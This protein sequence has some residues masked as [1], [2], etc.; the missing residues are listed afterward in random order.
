MVS[1]LLRFCSTDSIDWHR[2]QW[3]QL[4]SMI[5]RQQ[6]PHALLLTGLQGLGKQ[7]FA[8]GLA[9][10]LLC[11]HVD[12]MN[13]ACG[14]CR[15]CLWLASNSHPD[16]SVVSP[17]G[18]SRSI[19]VDQI[20]QLHQKAYQSS[21][22]GGYRIIV[23]APAEAMN[24]AAANALLKLLEEP[25]DET[26]LLLLSHQAQLLLPTLRSRCQSVY[27]PPLSDESLLTLYANTEN[28]EAYLPLMFGAPFRLQGLIDDKRAESHQEILR[29]TVALIEGFKEP[30]NYA[31]CWQSLALE[32][33]LESLL[34]W[35]TEASKW[36]LIGKNDD[37]SKESKELLIRWSRHI[38]LPQLFDV[39]EHLLETKKYLSEKIAINHTLWL[40]GIAL[41]LT[42]DVSQQGR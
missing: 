19:K 17:E 26:L 12:K 28:I 34:L 38:Q 18:D 16:L 8:M 4:Q 30:C 15:A 22:N 9:K 10:R 31:S 24:V 20:R 37:L 11:E 39:L 23:I 35:M 41:R 13:E 33:F 36:Q 7:Q 6:L 2:F 40:E 25:N 27:F 32:V 5:V 3:A 21:H 14:Q 1:D 29:D 42:G